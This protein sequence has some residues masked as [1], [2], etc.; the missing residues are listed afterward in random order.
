MRTSYIYAEGCILITAHICSPSPLWLGSFFLFFLPSLT[1]ISM[2]LIA[3][4]SFLIAIVPASGVASDSFPLHLIYFL[5]ALT[6]LPL[7]T[8]LFPLYVLFMCLFQYVNDSFWGHLCILPILFNSDFS[9]LWIFQYI[10]HCLYILFMTSLIEII[11]YSLFFNF[12]CRL[13]LSLSPS[14]VHIHPFGSVSC[15]LISPCLSHLCHIHPPHFPCIWV[16]ISVFYHHFIFYHYLPAHHILSLLW[17]TI[18]CKCIF[19]FV[20]KYANIL[21]LLYWINILPCYCTFLL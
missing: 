10:H 4:G 17:F 19:P 20:N 21:N 18:S 6:L 2:W 15:F 1:S 12:I 11:I 8:P 16:I 14:F 9:F 7:W 13:D 5:A 3:C